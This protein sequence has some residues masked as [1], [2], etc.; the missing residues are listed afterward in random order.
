MSSD[1]A[2]EFCTDRQG[3]GNF[4]EVQKSYE[5]QLAA[6]KAELSQARVS[7]SYMPPVSKLTLQQGAAAVDQ[8]YKLEQQLMLSAWHEL[9]SRTVRDHIA[10]AGTRRP[11]HRPV[12][13]SW[14]SRQRRHVSSGTLWAIR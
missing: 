4:D 12:G 6:L 1:H 8:R 7:Q 9:G 2:R 14:L 5:N 13:T 11:I 10:A 3:S